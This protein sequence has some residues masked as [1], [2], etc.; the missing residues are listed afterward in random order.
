[1]VRPSVRTKSGFAISLYM[2]MVREYMGE[3]WTAEKQIKALIKN[4]G[5]SVNQSGLFLSSTSKD[6]NKFTVN[7]RSVAF[8]P[9]T[10]IQKET[11]E[12]FDEGMVIS[13]R[14]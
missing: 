7:R 8:I 6:V 2:V 5:G 14:I 12:L 1:M 9:R 4:A 13:F 10:K 11:L 3:G